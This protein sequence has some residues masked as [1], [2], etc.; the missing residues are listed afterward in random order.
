MGTITSDLKTKFRQGNL[1]MKLIYINIAVFVVVRLSVVLFTLFRG[2]F[3]GILSYLQ[4]SSDPATVLFR[5]WTMVTYMFLH[6][7]VL[8][9]LFNLLWLYWF[10]SLFLRCFT[11]KQMAGL[12]LIGG[13]AGGMLYIASYNLFP[14]FTDLVGNS[15]LMGASASILAI[16]VAVAFH[17]PNDE[18]HLM[19]LGRVKLK[20]IA[21]ATIVIDLL[22]VT[23]SNAGGNIAHLGGALAGYLFAKQYAKGSDLTSFINRV[24][25]KVVNLFKRR[26]TMRVKSPHRETDYEYNSRKKSDEEELNRILEKLKQV[27]YATLSSDEKKRLFEAGK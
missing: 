1:L 15:F 12:Y 26:P 25:D 11:E 17:I 16:V 21:V 18:V 13:L 20:W 8:H 3:S 7:D 27:G 23:S 2:D 5:P 4:L 10:G 6:Y 14:Y 9:I 22:S 19:F 24:V